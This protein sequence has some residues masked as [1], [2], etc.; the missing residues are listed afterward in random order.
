[1]TDSAFHNVF[2][3]DDSPH[4]KAGMPPFRVKTALAEGGE[5][6]TRFQHLFW[7]RTYSAPQ[8]PRCSSGSWISLARP[9][10]LFD[11]GLTQGA[12][13]AAED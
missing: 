3:T 2:N 13:L 8:R 9:V 11:T 1:M 5:G 10:T 6:V 4:R 7:K 12:G